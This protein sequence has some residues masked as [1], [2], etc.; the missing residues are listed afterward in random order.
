MNN[1]LWLDIWQKKGKHSY[2]Q[3][4]KYNGWEHFKQEEYLTFLQRSFVPVV[5]KITN[6]KK[7]LEVGCGAGS[8]LKYVSEINKNLELNGFD[9]SES[10]IEVCKKNLNGNF[11]TCDIN[12]EKWPFIEQNAFDVVL[13]CGVF[14]YFNS[15]ENATAAIQKS[16]KL[17]N[18][19][20]ILFIT[21][22]SDLSKKDLALEIRKETHS[23]TKK[24]FS[25][26]DI[27]H[28]YYDKQFFLEIAQKNELKVHFFDHEEI[29]DFDWNISRKYR[30]NVLLEK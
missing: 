17:L 3:L 8:S 9:Y 23:T 28:L 15:Y 7:V 4:H 26:D 12:E 27:Q 18:K 1:N 30:Y 24:F 19:D 14:I 6:S 16:L 11:F 10:L 20:G 29:C 25:K 21:D 5:K 2:D 13:S 22:I